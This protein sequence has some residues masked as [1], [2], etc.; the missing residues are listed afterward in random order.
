VGVPPIA[1]YL[2]LCPFSFTS[3]AL[4]NAGVV[5]GLIGWL[6]ISL[7]NGA[8]YGVLGFG[9]GLRVEKRKA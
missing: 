4:D 8:F 9:F 2:L 1:I 7:V 3:I 6:F 5:G